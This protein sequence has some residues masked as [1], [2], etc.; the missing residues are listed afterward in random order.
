LSD[1]FGDAVCEEEVFVFCV[2]GDGKE[3]YHRQIDISVKLFEGGRFRGW[4]TLVL[5]D[6][7]LRILDRIDGSSTCVGGGSRKLRRQGMIIVRWNPLG[8]LMDF[9]PD[10][11]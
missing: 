1:D 8:N 7:G 2:N 11:A 6:G 5:R 4:L 10:L 9:C 3:R